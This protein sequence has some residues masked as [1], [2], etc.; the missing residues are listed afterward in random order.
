MDVER[1]CGAVWCAPRVGQL[2]AQ[3]KLLNKLPS[4]PLQKRPMA[5]VQ[6]QAAA[7]QD[8]GSQRVSLR[9][10]VSY[11]AARAPEYHPP[12]PLHIIDTLNG[13]FCS[14]LHGELHAASLLQ[15]GLA[16]LTWQLRAACNVELLRR[17][18]IRP[19]VPLV[20]VVIQGPAQ[21]LDQPAN[22]MLCSTLPG[23]HM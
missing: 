23:N 14:T 12:A 3:A 6:Q 17:L 10:A 18:V 11:S 22:L 19:T 9:N 21:D 5:S 8:L 20:C 16:I 4:R 15:E 7:P 1:R 13:V 2:R